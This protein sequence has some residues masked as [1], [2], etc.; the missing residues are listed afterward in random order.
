MTG[1]WRIMLAVAATA[2]PSLCVPDNVAY[3][4]YTSGS[5]GTPK[6]VGVTHAAIIRLARGQVPGVQGTS[7]DVFLQLAP[8]AFEG[9]VAAAIERKLGAFERQDPVDRIVEEIAI[10]ADHDHRAR[11]AGNVIFEP[12]RPFEV[13]IIGRLVEQEQVGLREERCRERHPHAPAAGE[14]RARAL[15]FFV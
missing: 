1:R 7:G 12:E 11:V 9:G 4:L 5:T 2:L 10:V 14:F 15:L 13:E 8:L 3:E 6:G